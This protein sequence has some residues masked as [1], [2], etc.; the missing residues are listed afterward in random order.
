MNGYNPYAYPQPQQPQQPQYPYDPRLEKL[1]ALD[2][3]IRE[4]EGRLYANSQSSPQSS[5][6]VPHNGG[7]QTPFTGMSVIPVQSEEEAFKDPPAIDGSKQYY[8]NEAAKAFYVKYFD[9]SIPKTIKQVY[10]LVD[11]SVIEETP[12]KEAL[13]PA[14]TELSEKVSGIEESF[15]DFLEDFREVA[16]IVRKSETKKKAG[17]KDDK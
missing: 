10:T 14:L 5:S 3:K 6:P 17:A 16:K 4:M 2:S 13:S 8:Y 9:M 11:D 15:A 1:N 12:E 7:E